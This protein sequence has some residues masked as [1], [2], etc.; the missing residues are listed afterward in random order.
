MAPASPAVQGS[1]VMG[2]GATIRRAF[3]PYEYQI[4]A[5]YRAIYV[6]LEDYAVKLRQHAPE[7]TRILEVGGGEGAMTELLARDYPDAEILAIDITPKIGRLY[8][9]RRKGVTFREVSVQE[10]AVEQPASFD[11][12]VLSDVV[13]HIPAHLRVEVLQAL[14]ACIAPGGKFVLKDWARTPT[15][16]HWLCYASD[17]WLTGDRIAYLTPDEMKALM[18]QSA[19]DLKLVDESQVSP[20][21]NNFA[22]AFQCPSAA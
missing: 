17:R 6:S 21:A 2:I 7:A 20:W 10:I 9:G 14:A 11:L 22:I 18:A 8:R 15:P 13:H 3:G 1:Y 4:A 5:A 19:P 16:I 12:V